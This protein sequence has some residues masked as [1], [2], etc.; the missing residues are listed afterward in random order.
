VSAPKSKELDKFV[1]EVQERGYQGYFNLKLIRMPEVENTLLVFDVN[2][3]VF[4]IAW[5]SYI[6][7]FSAFIF[8]KLWLINIACV[9]LLLGF[10]W[11][12]FFF[13]FLFLIGAKK[14]GVKGRIRLL[15]DSKTI[16]RVV[17]YV[18]KR[19]F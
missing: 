18:S 2:I 8:S 11:S 6:F 5:V 9:F 16:K 7:I 4:N 12:R 3:S 1:S 10:F 14:A 13:Y 15:M 17:E 19:G